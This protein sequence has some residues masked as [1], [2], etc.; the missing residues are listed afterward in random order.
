MM[1]IQHDPL[2]TADDVARRFRVTVSTVNRWVRDGIIPCI[3]P[4][5]RIVRFNLGEVE[6]AIAK[7][8][9]EFP[10]ESD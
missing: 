4:S 6:R 10:D 5:R 7:S 1:Q 3:R 2:A 8:P 9:L